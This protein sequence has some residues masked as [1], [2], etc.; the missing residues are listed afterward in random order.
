MSGIGKG[1]IP[2]IK[3]PAT[4]TFTCFADPDWQDL[5]RCGADIKNWLW[6]AAKD[7]ARVCMRTIWDM[8]SRQTP[9][10][11][12]LLNYTDLNRNNCHEAPVITWFIAY[13]PGSL[14]IDRE[15]S[16]CPVDDPL[17][18]IPSKWGNRIM[19]AV[20]EGLQKVSYNEKGVLIGRTFDGEDWVD[21]NRFLISRG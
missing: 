20:Q 3:F 6:Y 9:E 8:D 4:Y 15:P 10:S 14:F 21:R 17:L 1:I 5:M 16:S 13:A 2:V 11:F 19:K 12:N 7:M 18:Y